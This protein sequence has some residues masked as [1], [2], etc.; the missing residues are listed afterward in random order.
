MIENEL[1]E[2]APSSLPARRLLLDPSGG[3]R[4]RH[5]RERDFRFAG[6]ASGEAQVSL[7]PGVAT[8]TPA[9]VVPPMLVARSTTLAVRV[10]DRLCSRI[11]E[12]K[13]SGWDR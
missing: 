11:A 8:A 6:G 7:C 13:P 5:S 2:A 9:A 3:L 4:G 1:S 10:R 12:A